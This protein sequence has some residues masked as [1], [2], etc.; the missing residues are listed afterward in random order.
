MRTVFNFKIGVTKVLLLL[1]VGTAWADCPD[2]REVAIPS[3]DSTEPRAI[4]KWEIPVVGGI[5]EGQLD[6]LRGQ[7]SIELKVLSGS[8][9]KLHAM[10]LDS[11]GLKELQL[12]VGVGGCSKNSIDDTTTTCNA[13]GLSAR[14]TRSISDPGSVGDNGCTRYD[15]LIENLVPIETEL[16]SRYY[17]VGID[18]INFDD[19]GST[20]RASLHLKLVGA[21]LPS[22]PPPPCPLGFKCC[23][24]ITQDHKCKGRCMR[25]QTAC[26]LPN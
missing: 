11:Q 21:E 1:A 16:R 10:G 3:T 13:P 14:P 17:E 7:R 18:A 19:D 12:W 22:P 26:P 5:W 15:L 24:D 25:E 8:K 6:S 23:G 9:V 20:N 4:V 2:G